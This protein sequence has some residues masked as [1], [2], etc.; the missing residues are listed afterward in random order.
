MS[1]AKPQLKPQ[2]IRILKTLLEHN[3]YLSTTQVAEITGI[4]WN[5]ADKY[6]EQFW[7]CCWIE[8]VKRGNRNY[9]RAYRK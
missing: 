8:K 9:W 2:E 4:S 1:K 7:K 6:L 3:Y 5:T